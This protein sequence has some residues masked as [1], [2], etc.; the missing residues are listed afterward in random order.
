M[1]F[2]TYAF[3]CLSFTSIIL[4]GVR[5]LMSSFYTLSYIAKSFSSSTN[6]IGNPKNL[7]TTLNFFFIFNSGVTLILAIW[8]FYSPIMKS[9]AWKSRVE[10]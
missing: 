9:S 1:S 6:F 10:L 2:F 4:I 3:A 5:A 7:E 8:I